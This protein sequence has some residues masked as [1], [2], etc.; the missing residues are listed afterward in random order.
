M[1]SRRLPHPST[2]D[3]NVLI[4]PVAAEEQKRRIDAAVAERAYEIFQK[5]G[6][7]GWHELEDW[8]QAEAQVRSNVCVGITTQDHA[9]FIATDAAGFEPGTL[10][11]W[12]APRQLT[13]CGNARVHGPQ[14]I[15]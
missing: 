5:R 9:V 11:V 4:V 2:P 15:G 6:G 1:N 12:V 3:T 7:M 10:E 13:I 8:H 14:P